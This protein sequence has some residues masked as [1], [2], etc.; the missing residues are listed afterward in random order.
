M[1]KRALSPL[2]DVTE[3]QATSLGQMITAG[4]SSNGSSRRSS[5]VQ[6]NNGAS[7]SS[8]TTQFLQH[9]RRG[10]FVSR[11]ESPTPAP[12]Q[13][14]LSAPFH[15][16]IYRPPH[17]RHRN[18][19]HGLKSPIAHY[20]RVRTPSLRGQTRPREPS[21]ASTHRSSISGSRGPSTVPIAEDEDDDVG[22]SPHAASTAAPGVH[23]PPSRQGSE[24]LSTSTWSPTGPSALTAEAVAR[25][26]N[27]QMPSSTI[28][29]LN[30]TMTL[31]SLASSRYADELEAQINSAAQQALYP[32]AG[33]ADWGARPSFYKTFS[34]GNSNSD[35]DDIELSAED[36]MRSSLTDSYIMSRRNSTASGY[37]GGEGVVDIFE[38]GDRL[39]PGMNHDG[40]I[41]TIAQTSS[42]FDEQEGDLT[43][44]KLEVVGK[45]GEGSYACVYLVKEVFDD[46]QDGSQRGRASSLL[47]AD[48]LVDASATAPASDDN[49]GASSAPLSSTPIA[50]PISR[51]PSFHSA[52]GG[53]GETGDVT[54][55]EGVFGSTLKADESP[56]ASRRAQEQTEARR[57]REFALKCLCKRDLS[58]EMLEVQRLESTVH[59]SI[60]AHPNI[61]TLYRTYE[62]PDWLFLVLEY[63]P[64]QDLFFWL[65][66]AQDEMHTS[67]SS[68]S[69]SSVASFSVTDLEP[70][71]NT[72]T[73]TDSTPPDPSLLAT[74]AGV[75]IL[76]RRRLRLISR[77]FQQMCSAVQFC[78]DRG[79][80]HRD[81]KP[82]N[83]IVEDMRWGSPLRDANNNLSSSVSLNH[84]IRNSD[85]KVKV[86]LTDFGLATAEERCDDFE[87]GSKPYMSYE[88]RNDVEA[89]YDPKMA[90]VWS[91]GIV[92]LNMLF[93]RN[94]FR[95][96]AVDRCPSFAAFREEPVRFL[97]EAFDGLTE[98]A[99]TFLV[100]RIFCDVQI[101]QRAT[102]AEFGAWAADLNEHMGL[103]DST[104][105][106]TPSRGAS[107][108]ITNQLHHSRSHSSLL[109]ASSSMIMVHSLVS[110]PLEPNSAEPGW[111]LPAKLDEPHDSSA[112]D[113]EIVEVLI[114]TQDGGPLNP[115]GTGSSSV[116]SS[117]I[118]SHFPGRGRSDTRDDAESSDDEH[119]HEQDHGLNKPAS[120]GRRRKRGARKGRSTSKQQTPSI[121]GSPRVEAVRSAPSLEQLS[122]KVREYKRE[123]NGLSHD[124]L[125]M[126][127][128]EAS[129]NLARE[130]SKAT[131]EKRAVDVK[132]ASLPQ[133]PQM[134]LGQGPSAEPLLHQGRGSADY[135]LAPARSPRH[136]PLQ[137]YGRTHA[138]SWR[139]LNESTVTISSLA[140]VSTM[141]SVL[142][143]DASIYSTASAP[144]AFARRSY[145]S[146]RQQRQQRGLFGK[147]S[148]GLQTINERAK[149][150][151][152]ASY[153]A[154]IFGGS[155]DGPSRSHHHNQ[156]RRRE[157]R[158]EHSYHG[159]E[160][161]YSMDP[162]RGSSKRDTHRHESRTRGSSSQASDSPSSS[163]YLTPQN[164][165]RSKTST[166]NSSSFSSSSASSLPL[167]KDASMGS[168]SLMEANGGGRSSSSDATSGQ[169]QLHHA[170]AQ[171]SVTAGSL[172]V[173]GGRPAPPSRASN[174]NS[175]AADS[176]GAGGSATGGKV[177]SKF[178][179]S[180]KS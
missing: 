76:S 80:S 104:C 140:S 151:L 162:Y 45:L 15:P 44:S 30:R 117:P 69:N 55:T 66:Q 87:C 99:A 8:S 82:E 6:L 19:G 178:F 70:E 42:G 144:A 64:G 57:G 61:V 142:S 92:L 9:S 78:H 51:L 4:A 134:R 49:E 56:L 46:D 128:A 33:T 58:P 93:H 152:D 143:D 53:G 32:N 10:S 156:H 112:E 168:G 155:R 22:N 74:T 75:S 161:D 119:E 54:L 26:L 83:F 21:I 107:M 164:D 113:E 167:R 67:S 157:L 125:L 1:G 121:Q 43:G 127:L 18:S 108:G 63:C 88:C 106:S 131:Q 150:E 41:I 5:F 47:I 71:P 166:S 65:E 17:L 101:S 25:H 158:E 91:L 133:R 103:V 90:D 148:S 48:A 52:G 72:A 38:I 160:R 24:K 120:Q 135:E 59:Q 89:T 171:H 136:P 29:P 105:S 173:N 163:K 149:K 95:E 114:G 180:G 174:S 37:G 20:D 31:S 35:K 139:D 126:D 40:H 11:T 141:N 23:R 111:T 147:S 50:A 153:L 34:V 109:S 124:D 28:P 137:D 2:A 79:I 94:P 14:N 27:S 60:P 130:I 81:L 73:V 170:K 85:G 146:F 86:K 116:K 62:T 169:Q 100:Q 177:F 102:A 159:R 129:Q 36:M 68:S 98:R 13:S 138:T 110:P 165:Q 145:D 7:S 12:V 122:D 84:S 132:V 176:K 77:M 175:N 39:G 118:E 97:R 172:M 96:P 115:G 123:P 179:R 154:E 3:G 16:G